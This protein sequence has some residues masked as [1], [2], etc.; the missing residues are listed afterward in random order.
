MAEGG[1]G[2]AKPEEKDKKEDEKKPKYHPPRK[3]ELID[4]GIN[5]D[6]N[7]IY[8]TVKLPN[9]VGI[10]EH[11]YDAKTHDME[12]E[13]E[14]YRG[15]VHNM[16]RW[17]YKTDDDKGEGEILR[18]ENGVP[19]RESNTRL[20]KWSDG[21]YTLYVGREVMD[22]DNLDRS[23]PVDS[24]DEVMAGFAGING[25]LSIAQRNAH[26]L[27]PTKKEL[28]GPPKEG[29]EAMDIDDGDEEVGQAKSAGTILENIGPIASRFTLR[30]SSLTS[31]A[32]RSLKL[33][34]QKRAVKR[35]RIAE[36]V[37]ELDPEKEKMK[38]N[39][40]RDD[41]AKNEARKAS[42]GGGRRSGG[43]GRRR[44]MNASY[45][46]EDEDDYDGVNLSRLKRQTMRRDYDD[47]EEEM[48]YGEDSEEEEDSE[49]MQKKKRKRGDALKAALE[50]SK[51]D[52]EGA[53]AVDESSESEGQVVFG[54]DDDDDEE[55]AAFPKKRAKKVLDDDDDDE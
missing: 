39:K 14:Y 9:L 11:A 2:A 28:M 35:A 5:A 10:Q 41:V 7:V 54:D 34:V 31:D 47:D 55:G 48:D 49:W 51:D 46:E 42:G 6:N 50:K 19:I 45:L 24:P 36:Y 29:E 18:D 38:R 30:P 40:N 26:I 17:R 44:G 23:V 16:I 33:T 13:E 22:V 53:K 32:H 52:E 25:Y 15:Y 21:S 37:T 12:A 27:P 1:D 20:V 8:H 4:H 3:M 43:G